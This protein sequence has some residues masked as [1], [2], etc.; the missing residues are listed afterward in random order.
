MYTLISASADFIALGSI[1]SHFVFVI[2]GVVSADD[3]LYKFVSN[4]VYLGKSVEL[5]TFNA[6]EH[7]PCFFKA[8]HS[9]A[10]EVDLCDVT[11][12]DDL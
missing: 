5:D 2:K 9:A 12:N 1:A 4:D 11:G 10:W 3:T 8:A 7:F 6:R